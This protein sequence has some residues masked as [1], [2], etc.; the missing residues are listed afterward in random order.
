VALY[1]AE[2]W[3]SGSRRSRRMES[4][5]EEGNAINLLHSEIQNE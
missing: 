4:Y 1:A 5:K 3:D 2:T